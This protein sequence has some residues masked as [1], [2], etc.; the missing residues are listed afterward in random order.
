MSTTW[1][2][3]SPTSEQFMAPGWYIDPADTQVKRRWD[4]YGWTADAMPVPPQ[5]AH[6]ERS[7]LTDAAARTAR[8]LWARNPA[9]LLALAVCALYLVVDNYTNV[10]MLGL[11]PISLSIQAI[12]SREPLCISAVAATIIAIA[13]PFVLFH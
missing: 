13:A 12:R 5:P 2:N 11:I 4:G 10:V 3:H 9:S 7:D 1:D 6:R 8:N